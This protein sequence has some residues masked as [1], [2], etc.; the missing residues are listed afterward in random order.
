M[1]N[2]HILDAYRFKMKYVN[3]Y[4]ISGNFDPKNPLYGVYEFKRG[5]NGQVIEM[6]GEFTYK[7]SKTYPIYNALRHIKIGIRNIIKR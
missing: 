5:F 3:F 1:Y 6:I 2:E 7:V 4:G